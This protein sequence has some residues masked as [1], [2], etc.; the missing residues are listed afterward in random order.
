MKSNKPENV[1][2]NREKQ[3]MLRIALTG[4]Q[5]GVLGSNWAHLSFKSAQ[6]GSKIGEIGL[7]GL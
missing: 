4:F 6:L 2:L 7:G 1:R 5:V 3:G